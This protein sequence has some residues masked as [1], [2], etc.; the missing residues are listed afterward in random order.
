MVFDKD[1]VGVVT[2][3]RNKG[4][5]RFALTRRSAPLSRQNPTKINLPLGMLLSFF[6]CLAI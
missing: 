2:D 3:S 6:S 4:W 1:D 5:R